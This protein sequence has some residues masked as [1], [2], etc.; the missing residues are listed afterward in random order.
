MPEVYQAPSRDR[1]RQGGVG[2]GTTGPLGADRDSS[3]GGSSVG[4]HAPEQPQGNNTAL[5]SN[6]GTGGITDAC[7]LSDSSAVPIARKGVRYLRRCIAAGND[8][9]RSRPAA[10]PRAE[11]HAAASL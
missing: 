1:P 10:L 11:R 2:H 3:N 5:R 9:T 6:A 8:Q 4:Y 7:G